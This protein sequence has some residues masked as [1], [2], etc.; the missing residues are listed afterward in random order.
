MKECKICGEL[1]PIEQF[2]KYHR[3]CK[4]CQRIKVNSSKNQQICY[5]N[6]KNELLAQ[7]RRKEV[8]ISSSIIDKYNR[9]AK[10]M[11][12]SYGQLQALIYEGKVTI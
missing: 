2:N 11:G 7:K 8:A 5:E 6:H 4:D 3:E 9:K 12:I 10:E 1:K